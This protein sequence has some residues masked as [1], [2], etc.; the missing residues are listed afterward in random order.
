MVEIKWT[1][2]GPRQAK[3]QEESSRR[4]LIPLL[5]WRRSDGEA[6]PCLFQ[7]HNTLSCS[8]PL[9]LVGSWVTLK[10]AVNGLSVFSFCVLI[11]M[12]DL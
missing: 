7:I 1:K 4:W 9:S 10:E 3:H 8:F 12:A 5:V 2:P 11:Q 6:C